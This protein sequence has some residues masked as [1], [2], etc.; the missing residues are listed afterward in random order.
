MQDTWSEEDSA[1]YRDLAAIAVPS[2]AEQMAT[3]IALV[4]FDRDARFSAVEIGG[5]E[6][7]L[8]EALLECFTGATVVAFDGS[9]QM[10][11]A[12]RSRLARFGDRARVA[13]FDLFA[14]DWLERID[15][16]GVV[17]S[18]LCIHHFDHGQKRAFF[19][20]A[21]SRLAPGGA[22]LIADIVEPQRGVV[23][24]LFA[25]TYDRAAEAESVRLTGGDALYRKLMAAEWN[26]FRFP[27][28]G[29]D[30]PSPL[31]DQLEWLRTAG[32]AAA[33]CFWMK[34][35]HA[36]YGGYLAGGADPGEPLSYA[37]ALDSVER[38]LAL[39]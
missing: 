18:S 30:K 3:L 21:A 25:E 23:N 17:M 39:R 34:A 1:Q 36:V 29:V 33:D 24:Q 37:Q 19:R 28:P 26:I 6:G 10:R 16:A 20:E 7:I 14:P 4:P 15:G 9:E 5:G 32:F 38:A 13:A 12:A 31:A 22:L 35:G 11:E 27:D 8:S 2:R